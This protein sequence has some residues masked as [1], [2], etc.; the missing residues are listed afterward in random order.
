MEVPGAKGHLIMKINAQQ[1]IGIKD[2]F[3]TQ[4]RLNYETYLTMMLRAATKLSH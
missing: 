3:K 2:M 4:I 1:T